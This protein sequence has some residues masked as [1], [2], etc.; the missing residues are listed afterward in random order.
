MCLDIGVLESKLRDCWEEEY[1]KKKN[2]QRKALVR[3]SFSFADLEVGLSFP[4]FNV[5]KGRAVV[6]AYLF[7]FVWLFSAFL[8]IA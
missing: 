5:A 1:F 4:L 3:R 6:R 8:R 7:S 2:V